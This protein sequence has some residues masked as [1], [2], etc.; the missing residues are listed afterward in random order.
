MGTHVNQISPLESTHGPWTETVPYLL[1]YWLGEHSRERRLANLYQEKAVQVSVRS[2]Q[3]V[4]LE[5]LGPAT[6]LHGSFI[7]TV[8][9]T[10]YERLSPVVCHTNTL[11]E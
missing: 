10:V 5:E 2:P 9:R 4:S 7:G 6:A 8:P 11:T 3:P 1:A